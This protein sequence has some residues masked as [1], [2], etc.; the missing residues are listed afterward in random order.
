M[1]VEVSKMNCRPGLIKAQAQNGSERVRLLIVARTATDTDERPL[2]CGS[3]QARQPFQEE[4]GE[5]SDVDGGGRQ[6]V[7]RRGLGT[8]TK[9]GHSGP[10]GLMAAQLDV[11]VDRFPLK[12]FGMEGSGQR[13][14]IVQ[15]EAIVSGAWGEVLKVVGEH[16]VDTAPDATLGPAQRCELRAG[17]ADLLG[18]VETDEAQRPAGVED[19]VG[20][21]GVGVNIE[22]GGWGNVARD[23]QG[24]AHNNHFAHLLGN[25]WDQPDGQGQIGKRPY[26][27]QGEGARRSFD[28]LTEEDGGRLQDRG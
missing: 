9:P 23:A 12:H 24:S 5:A 28:T 27:D 26:G 20:S 25:L 7:G 16:S 21:L 2:P 1:R 11:N 18:G 3:E 4:S 10:W 19:D 17:Q 22:L 15:V 14:W 13:Q 8:A 6:D